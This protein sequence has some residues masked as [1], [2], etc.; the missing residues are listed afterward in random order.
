MR[1]TKFEISSNKT[2]IYVDTNVLCNNLFVNTKNRPLIVVE[3][4]AASTVRVSLVQ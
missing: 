2:K 3:T 4:Y 1:K